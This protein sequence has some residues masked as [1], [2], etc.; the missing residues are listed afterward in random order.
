MDQLDCFVEWPSVMTYGI[1][2]LYYGL[3]EQKYW[4]CD[5]P[6][7]LW[8]WKLIRKKERKNNTR[9]DDVSRV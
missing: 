7:D 9:W 6:Q 5:V 1:C 8:K 2:C 3:V 4:M